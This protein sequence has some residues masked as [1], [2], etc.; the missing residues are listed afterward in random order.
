VYTATLSIERLRRLLPEIEER[1]LDMALCPTEDIAGPGG[2]VYITAQTPLTAKH[3]DWLERRNPSPDAPVYL[4]V[5]FVRRAE[6]GAA[7]PAPHL[8]QSPDLGIMDDVPP[9]E[10]QREA[11]AEELSKG[12][13]TSAR[14]VAARAQSM[15]QLLRRA[16]PNAVDLRGPD[17]EAGLREFERSFSQFH[18]AVKKALGEYLQGNTLVMDLILRYHLDRPTVRHGLTVAAFATEMASLLALRDGAAEPEVDPSRALHGYFGDL[19]AAQ[20]QEQLGESQGELSPEEIGELRLRLFRNEL[21]EIF[22]GGFM[23]DCGMWTEPGFLEE[24]HEAKGRRLIGQ[25]EEVGRYAPSLA[26]IVLFHSDI[27]R[28]ARRPGAVAIAE[29]PNDPQHAAFRT[30]FYDTPEE[31][32]S[33]AELQSGD[34]HAEVLSDADLRKILPV[35]LGE[36]YTSQTQDVYDKSPVEVLGDLAQHVRGGLFLRYIVVLCNSRVEVVAPRRALVALEGHIPMFTATA[37]NPRKVQRL[38]VDGYDAGSLHHGSDRNS[39]HLVSLFICRRD[40]SRI[41]ADYIAAQ[42]PAL[43]ERT[44]GPESRMYLPAGRH[45]NSISYRVTGFMSEDVYARVLGGYEQELRRREGP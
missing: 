15:Y 1:E 2:G 42:D 28:L 8:E 5:A 37:K 25:T 4:E 11:R 43:W 24:G 18:G 33:R 35:A 14:D 3:V 16:D 19:S 17:T 40:G 44:A 31:A 21:V 29:N 41:K 12:V 10:G 27:T 23:H 34:V 39:P 26:K 22:L 30:E 36:H 13:A 38:D 45:R 7:A 9:S 32:G 6:Q 20:L